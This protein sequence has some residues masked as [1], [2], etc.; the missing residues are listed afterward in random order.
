MEKKKR[1]KSKM[2]GVGRSIRR[3]RVRKEGK[4]GGI[5]KI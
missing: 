4:K 2:K 3:E 5:R 1:V